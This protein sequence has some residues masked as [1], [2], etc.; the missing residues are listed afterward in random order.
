M[1]G[2]YTRFESFVSFY[3]VSAGI[4]GMALLIF[5]EV[6]GRYLFRTPIRGSSEIVELTMILVSFGG[7]AG[8]QRLHRHI[9]MDFLQVRFRGRRAGHA[10]EA[11][12]LF[13]C[14]V[15][16][17][18]LLGPLYGFTMQQKASGATTSYLLVRLWPVFWIIIVGIALQCVRMVIQLAQEIRALVRGE[19]APQEPTVATERLLTD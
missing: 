2:L 12:V 14:L 6:A 8:I 17:L 15:T 7:L 1:K 10:L 19:V 13:V 3:I 11:F 16:F 9:R 18:G 5:G 4:V